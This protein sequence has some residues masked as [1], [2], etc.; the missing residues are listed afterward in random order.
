MKKPRSTSLPWNDGRNHQAEVT[1]NWK[2]TMGF[3]QKE[4]MGSLSKERSFIGKI[5]IAEGWR[6][7]GEE[8]KV[9]RLSQK[10]KVFG[11]KGGKPDCSWQE[12]S[13]MSLNEDGRI[14][15]RLQEGI[16]DKDEDR[17]PLYVRRT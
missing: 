14:R 6:K 4:V 7:R 9:D 15:T 5:Q 2:E 1:E 12:K 10:L 3:G 8:I 11:G 16:E 17:S 13:G